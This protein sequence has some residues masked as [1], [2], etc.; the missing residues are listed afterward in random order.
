M[1]RL[2]SKVT[3]EGSSAW[4]FTTVA[5]CAI[6]EDADSLTDTCVIELPKKAKWEGHPVGAGGSP[7]VKRGDKITVM[8]GYDDVLKLRFSG[9]VRRV[10]ATTPVKLECEDGMFLLK[11]AA[12]QRKGFEEVTLDKLISTLLEGTSVKYRLVDTGI[13][14]GPYRITRWTVAEELAELQR[15]YGLKAYFIEVDGELTLYVGLRYP[16]GV[17]QRAGFSYGYNI[18]SNDLEYRRK[19]DIKLKVKAISVQPDNKRIEVE[20]GDKG[21]ELRTVYQYNVWG[22]EALETFAR[23]ELD[24][25]KYDG[26]QGSFETFG[27]PAVGKGD[28][29]RVEGE[30]GNK[31]NFLI[32]KVEVT[33]GTGGYRQKVTLGPVVG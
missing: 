6:T 33:F 4:E 18:I 25:F 26:Y 27:D 15:V 16:F 21:G 9:Y 23:G 24:R 14:L 20:V 3:I 5:S 2:C 1:L 17:G 12:A 29:A 7:P 10:S 8:L 31:G 22:I 30:D 32:K 19:G 28:V 11:Q 13:S